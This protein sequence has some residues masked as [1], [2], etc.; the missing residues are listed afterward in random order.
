LSPLIL[1][2]EAA[3]S[4]ETLATTYDITW[5]QN[6]KYHSQLHCMLFHI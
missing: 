6:P 1:K 3:R 4:S 2:I 5:F